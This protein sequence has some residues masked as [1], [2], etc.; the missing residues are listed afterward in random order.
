VDLLQICQP[1]RD[2]GA[3]GSTLSATQAAFSDFFGQLMASRQVFKLGFQ[4][5]SD[6]DRLQESYPWLLCF[7]GG[8]DSSSSSSAPGIIQGHV[9]IIQLAR[10]LHP[11]LANLAHT[12]LSRLVASVLGRPLDKAQQRSSWAERPL[13]PEQLLYAATDASCLVALFDELVREYPGAW[14]AEF[15]NTMDNGLRRL[16]GPK[17]PRGT[18]CRGG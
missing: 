8:G 13:S 7:G 4:L 10:T 2:P 11:R 12:S 5:G 16:P 15:L 9:H 14:A 17:Q 3:D 18:V 1:G 6:L